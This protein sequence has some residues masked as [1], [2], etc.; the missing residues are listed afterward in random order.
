MGSD[1]L[2]VWIYRSIWVYFFSTFVWTSL[3]PVFIFVYPPTRYSDFLLVLLL[4][5]EW[6]IG[7][8]MCVLQY[9]VCTCFVSY[10]LVLCADPSAG[11][12]VLAA[13]A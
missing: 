4:M 3:I 6:P 10:A 1:L 12:N 8:C 9:R 2:L 5:D 11:R 7:P 13:A